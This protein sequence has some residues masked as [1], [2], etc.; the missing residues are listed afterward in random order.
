MQVGDGLLAVAPSDVGMHRPALDRAGTDE[1]HLDDEVVERA[2]PQ[3]RQR[4]HLCAALDL[5]HADRVGLAQ[6]V[7]DRVFLRDGGEVDVEPVCIADE[8]DRRSAARRA[9]PRP[10]RSNF[11]RPDRGA[12]VLVPLQHAAVLHA[13]PLDR[14]H[15]DH[16]SVADDHAARVDAEMAREMLDLGGQL[17][18]RRRGIVVRVGACGWCA[19]SASPC[20]RP[21]STTRPADR[22]RSR[23]PWPCRAPTTSRDR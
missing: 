6:H 15:L 7:V 4:G 17:E 5:E 18:H 3:A 20:D 19:S 8:I 22:W 14:A 2:R 12:V 10:S 1:R 13:A 16:R 23:A 11:T 9:C 21:A